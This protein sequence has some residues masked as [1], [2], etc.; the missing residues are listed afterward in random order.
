MA[1][2]FPPRR[3]LITC[4]RI[5]PLDEVTEACLSRRSDD[6]GSSALRP[7]LN[8]GFQPA[9]N[10]WAESDIEAFIL[11]YSS[12]AF[13]VPT[14]LTNSA[15][16]AKFACNRICVFNCMQTKRS[17]RSARPFSWETALTSGAEIVDV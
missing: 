13:D 11:T 9:V 3:N 16:N 14:R 7:V 10:D 12:H 6:R 17:L 5:A 15:E 8:R 4:H 1:H 2:Q